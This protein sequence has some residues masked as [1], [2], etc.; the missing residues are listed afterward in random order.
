[1]V[2]K[3]KLV[4]SNKG[5]NGPSEIAYTEEGCRC[6]QG[7]TLGEEKFALFSGEI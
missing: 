3:I 4:G 1:M 2:S 7:F 5:E 6:K